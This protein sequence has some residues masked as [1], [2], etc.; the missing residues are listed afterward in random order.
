MRGEEIS[1]DLHTLHF[2][3]KTHEVLEG[4]TAEDRELSPK[5]SFSVSL[6]RAT[7]AICLIAISVAAVLVGASCPCRLDFRP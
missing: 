5:T 2:S 1:L 7:G 4:S 6:E 3:G